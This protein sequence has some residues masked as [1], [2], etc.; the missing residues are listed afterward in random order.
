VLLGWLLPLGKIH[1]KFMQEVLESLE[2]EM[3]RRIIH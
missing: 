3:R 1:S 2:A